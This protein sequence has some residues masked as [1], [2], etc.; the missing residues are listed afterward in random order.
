MYGEMLNIDA[1]TRRCR[2]RMQPRDVLTTL[3]RLQERGCEM[4]QADGLTSVV[5]L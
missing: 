1:P 2:A 3:D 5:S 4:R